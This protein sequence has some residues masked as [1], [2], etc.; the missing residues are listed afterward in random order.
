MRHHRKHWLI[1]ITMIVVLLSF[2]VGTVS[3]ATTAIHREDA[4]ASIPAETE[5]DVPTIAPLVQ[6]QKTSGINSAVLLLSMFVCLAIGVVIGAFVAKAIDKKAFVEDYYWDHEEEVNALLTA[7]AAKDKIHREAREK[8]EMELREKRE[9]EKAAKAAA[10]AKTP[11]K[12][13]KAVPTVKEENEV[14]SF[15]SA[16]NPKVIFPDRIRKKTVT[17]VQDLT[18]PKTE[19]A[20]KG[21]PLEGLIAGDD[22]DY[23]GRPYY[24]DP[25]DKTGGVDPFYFDGTDRKYYEE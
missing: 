17:P 20:A 23:A 3:A 19:T 9:Q 22:L 4:A 18:P 24:Y 16:E 14:V 5:A 11:R 15:T 10:P 7:K 1:L 2:C 6:E 25:K 8:K 21:D 12:R 13:E